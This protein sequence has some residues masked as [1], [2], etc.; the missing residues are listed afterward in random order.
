MQCPNCKSTYCTDYIDTYSG[1]K[2]IYC[3]SCGN[4]TPVPMNYS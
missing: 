4:A 1:H 2:V 3:K